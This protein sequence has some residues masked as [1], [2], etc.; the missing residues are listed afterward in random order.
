MGT[1]I[2]DLHCKEVIC[3]GDGRRLGFVT[4]VE[5]NADDGCI[6]ALIV[7]GPCRFWGLTGRQDEYIIPWS[8]IRRIG[9][10]II[11]A[12]CCPDQCRIPRPKPRFWNQIP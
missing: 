9:P 4:D 5:F 10:D 6:V 11:L 3:V 1:R 8:S 7:P 2:T 12:E